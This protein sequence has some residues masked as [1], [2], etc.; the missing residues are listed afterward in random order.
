MGS[1]A[2]IPKVNSNCEVDSAKTSDTSSKKSTISTYFSFTKY[3]EPPRVE[4][5]QPA[6]DLYKKTVCESSWENIKMFIGLK[7][8]CGLFFQIL[9]ATD[10]SVCA[11]LRPHSRPSRSKRGY[12][13]RDG[14]LV[15]I[16][17][18]LLSISDDNFE[19]KKKIR[20]LGRKHLISGIGKSH[21]KVFNDVLIATLL[22]IPDIRECLITM[23]SWTALLDF[24]SKEMYIEDIKLVERSFETEIGDAVTD[25]IQF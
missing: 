15:H 23:T 24:T 25:G 2:S 10:E 19:T 4:D 7:P 8:F 1:A 5:S 18:F 20:A 12:V 17:E 9:E 22:N 11:L 16:I 14:L 6:M 13:T 3:L 21:I